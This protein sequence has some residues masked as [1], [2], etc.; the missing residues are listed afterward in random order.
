M[1]A[2]SREAILAVE[3][4][5][6]EQVPVPEWGGDVFVRGLTGT[7]RDAF[8]TSLWTGDGEGKKFKAE[9]I[10]AK[11]LVRSLV[12]ESGQRLFRDEDE[13]ALGGR[14]AAVL[15]RLFDVAQRLSGLGKKDV[16]NAVKN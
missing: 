1:A 15:D 5:K 4:I 8:E 2:L 14:N 10:R 6:R 3:D 7:E 16:E 9:N 12:D 11:L 13:A